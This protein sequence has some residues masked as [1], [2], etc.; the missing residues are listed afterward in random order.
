M[1][2]QNAGY[3]PLTGEKLAVTPVIE[4]ILMER[5]A[6]ACRGRRSALLKSGLCHHDH[7]ERVHA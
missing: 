3:E 1:R 2:E 5:R 7:L 6:P 4:G